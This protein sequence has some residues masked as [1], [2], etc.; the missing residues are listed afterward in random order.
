M[1]S[2]VGVN[3]AHPYLS[4]QIYACIGNK[5]RLLPLIR[6]AI[7][8]AVG[9]SCEG[10]RFLDAFAGSGVVS[11]LA[12]LM[13]FAVQANDWEEFSF[14]TNAAYVATSRSHCEQ[15]FADEGSLE[16]VLGELNGEGDLPPEEEYIARHYAPRSTDIS[17]ADYRTE[18]LFYTR[19]NALAIDRIR[20]GIDRRYPP[21]EADP[22]TVSR[23]RLLIAGLIYQAAT[24]ANTS[25]VFKAYH[26]GFGGHG[27]DALTRILAPIALLPPVLVDSPQQCRATRGDANELAATMTEPVDIAY[28]DPPYNQHQ[29]GSNYHLLTTIARWDRPPVSSER[30]VDG[31]FLEKAGIRHDW[32][33][34]K[35][36]YCSRKT[37]ATALADLVGGLPARH[38]LLSYSTDGMIDFEELL[39]I[40]SARG[41]ATIVSA[42]HVRYPGGKRS[43]TGRPDNTELVL[44]VDTSR[45]CS[46]G[47][48]ERI[49]RRIAIQRLRSGLRRR[50]RQDL[51]RRTFR[52]LGRGRLEADLGTPKIVLESRDYFTLSPPADLEDLTRREVESL[53]QKL[54]GCACA[55]KEQEMEE[56][57]AR[58]DS[59]GS[60][61]TRYVSLLPGCL[62]HLAHRKYRRSYEVWLERLGALKDSHPALYALV[63]KDLEKLDGIARKRF[64]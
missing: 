38:I 33:K 16:A 12:R 45:T 7:E 39:E 14:I 61:A 20:N 4:Q 35:S 32:V 62:K 49:R 34:T 25:G 6:R 46:T 19:E 64:E 11:R 9:E 2:R 3:L 57:F 58:L 27:G 1:V 54:D 30:G 15:L 52:D 59:G 18:R 48:L 26:R 63:A 41:R 29:Y 21:E 55:T 44:C 28:L 42:E 8:E 13:G 24:H 50:F 37:A 56:L 31:R 60:I 51:L 53:A 47:D 40:C 23:R 22:D 43:N 5:R 36:A 10:K 17:L